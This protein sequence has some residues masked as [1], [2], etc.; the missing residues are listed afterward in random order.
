[1][2]KSLKTT[3]LSIFFS[4]ATIFSPILAN[5]DTTTNNITPETPSPAEYRHQ[6]S[7]KCKLF[8]S[9]KQ[10]ELEINYKI[11]NLRQEAY[12]TQYHTEIIKQINALCKIK[13]EI[14][15]QLESLIKEINLMY[16]LCK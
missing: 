5:P 6:K 10:S 15:K 9:L 12:F 11:E 13:Q 2:N 16:D 7:E 3:L 14:P 4:I 1:M 8:L